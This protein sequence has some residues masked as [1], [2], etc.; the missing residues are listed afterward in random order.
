[1][2]IKENKSWPLSLLG[3]R[4]HS[5]CSRGPWEGDLGIGEWGAGHLE[6]QGDVQAWEWGPTCFQPPRHEQRVER[7]TARKK[8]NPL[9]KVQQSNL[10]YL[11]GGLPPAGN[12]WLGGSGALPLGSLG[13]FSRCWHKPWL[14]CGVGAGLE[15]GSG[16]ICRTLGPRNTGLWAP[17]SRGGILQW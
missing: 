13:T 16:S 9:H 15:G 2:D 4:G 6:F 11:G 5:Q 14:G 17:G 1:M 8:I 7:Q 12:P 3:L 10:I